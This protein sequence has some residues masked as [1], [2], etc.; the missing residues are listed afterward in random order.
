MWHCQH[1]EHHG[2]IVLVKHFITSYIITQDIYEVFNG[3][4]L[5]SI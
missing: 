2:T 5:V 3:V 4:K 1:R